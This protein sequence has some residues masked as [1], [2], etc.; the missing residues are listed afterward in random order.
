[1]VDQFPKMTIVIPTID[2]LHPTIQ[3]LWAFRGQLWVKGW[4]FVGLGFA[5][6]RCAQSLQNPLI[7]E[8]TLHHIGDSYY[9]LSYIP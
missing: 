4:G 7:R 2:A 9:D 3:M 6:E 5:C 1:M 8:Y